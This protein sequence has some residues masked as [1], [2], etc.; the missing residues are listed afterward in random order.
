MCAISKT[1]VKVLRLVD[2]DKPA[3]CYLYEALDRA[4]KSFCAYY[5]D[6]GLRGMREDY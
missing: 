6:K 2:A 5:E 3:M 1:L 4:N